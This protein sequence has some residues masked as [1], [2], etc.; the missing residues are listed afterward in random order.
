[1]DHSSSLTHCSTTTGDGGVFEGQPTVPVPDVDCKLVRI[2][3][4]IFALMSSYLNFLKSALMRSDASSAIATTGALVLPDT[5]FGMMEAS[6]TRRFETPFTC[7]RESVTDP[8]AQVP[9]GWYM[10]IVR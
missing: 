9:T 4:L 10:V 3:S 2:V 5:I 1:M 6:T 8:M 7:N